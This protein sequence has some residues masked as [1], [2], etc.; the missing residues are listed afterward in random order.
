[1]KKIYIITDLEGVTG[2]FKFSQTRDIGSP[3]F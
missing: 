3:A 2:L 1:M